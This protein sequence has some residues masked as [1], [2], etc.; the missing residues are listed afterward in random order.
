M[1]FDWAEYLRLAK[2]LAQR[3]DDE[4]AHRSAISRAYYAAYCRACAYLNQKN[5]PIPQG[6]GSHDRVWKSFK[7]LPGRTHSG[8]HNNGDRLKRKRVQADYYQQDSVS[9][10]DAAG[11]VAVSTIILGYLAQVSGQSQAE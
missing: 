1:A 10:K 6:E 9:A 7:D 8:I 4:A 3:Q 11:A 5:I 2:E